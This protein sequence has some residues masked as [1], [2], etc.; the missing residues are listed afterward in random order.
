M[1]FLL[2]LLLLFPSLTPPCPVRSRD[3][4]HTCYCLSG[5]SIAQHFGNTELQHEMIL[6]REENRLAPTHPIYNICPEKVAKAL[7]HFHRLPVPDEEDG[8]S[9]PAGAAASSDPQS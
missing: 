6:G 4:Y 8:V 1:C 7:L 2:L 3:F 9:D 5:L